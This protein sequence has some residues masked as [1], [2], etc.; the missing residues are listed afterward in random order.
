M[1]AIDSKKLVL[2][3]L[4]NMPLEKA[5]PFFLSLEKSGYR[6]DVC[7]IVSGID[8][9]TQAF[10]RARGVHL[11]PFQRDQ[12][13]PKWTFAAAW[14]G[15]FMRPSQRQVYESRLASTYMHPHTARHFFYQSYLQECS[16]AYSH[17]LLTDVRDVLF[18]ADPFAFEKP[19]GLCVFL[20][21]R[22]KTI[23]TCNHNTNSMLRGFGPEA[24]KELR[25]KPI[26]CAG[27][28]LGTTAAICDHL[29]KVTRLLC[30]KKQRESIDQSVH[31]FVINKQPPARLNVF[32]NFSGPVLTMAYV[33]PAR[34][35]FDDHGRVINTDGR[36]I[37]TLHQYDRHPQIIPKLLKALT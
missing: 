31:N 24:L 28:T 32:E 12:L 13:K 14:L 18:Q 34:M 27:T 30:A 26:A 25:D 6:G 22:S 10:L 5:S 33:D 11:I 15:A 9:P 4:S 35:R 20:A 36:V 16:A 1:S 8:L 2:G 7:M 17:V 37:N 23:G 21:D 29:S 3:L 19:D